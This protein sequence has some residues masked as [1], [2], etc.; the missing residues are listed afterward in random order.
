MTLGGVTYDYLP[1]TVA[2]DFIGQL[3]RTSSSTCDI[4]GVFLGRLQI[5][6]D[7]RVFRVRL[8]LSCCERPRSAIS[9]TLHEVYR[10]PDMVDT[11]AMLDRCRGVVWS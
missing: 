9:Q 7:V 1:R 10:L 4:D 6:K 8:D 2:V 5:P 3:Q 11:Y